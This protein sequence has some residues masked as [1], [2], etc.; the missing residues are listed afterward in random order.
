[1]SRCLGKADGDGEGKELMEA[2]I[3][4]CVQVLASGEVGALEAG[5]EFGFSVPCLPGGAW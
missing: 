5:E 2:K 3:D 4:V 1:M